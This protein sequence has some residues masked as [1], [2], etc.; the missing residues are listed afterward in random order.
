MN[1][2]LSAY[3]PH[4]LGNGRLRRT[5]GV[6]MAMLLGMLSLVGLSGASIQAAPIAPARVM[7]TYTVTNINDSGVNSLRQAIINANGSGGLDTIS[8]NIPGGGL[9]T[10][11][12]LSPLPPIVDPVIIDGYSQ[13]GS[14]CNTLPIGIN[15]VPQIELNGSS[16]AASGL[17]ILAGGS[18][19]NGLIINR[20]GLDGIDLQNL[21][22]NS[23]V[24]NFIGTNATG[25]APSPNLQR[26][27]LVETANNSIGTALPCDRNLI[28][29][30]AF[31]GVHING[32]NATANT[33][34]NNYIGTNAA[35]MGALPN[36]G[37][38]VLIT[39][40]SG[41]FVGNATQGTGNLISGNEGTGVLIQNSGQPANNNR[42]RGNFIGTKAPGSGALGNTRWGV[43]IVNTGLNQIGGTAA[44]AGNTI[45]Y[46]LF[47][48]VMLVG[49][50]SISNPIRTNSIHDNTDLGI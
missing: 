40:A 5:T 8:F 45:A 13:P 21:G 2:L 32:Q 24:G 15:A 4:R 26:G 46:N 16:V 37:S 49:A 6:L 31:N 36:N 29:S 10:I 48:G 41:N 30:N 39:S 17:V 14:S 9:H 20:F 38:G 1:T 7:L 28:S 12:L 18:T 43:Q 22:G 47:D 27:V 34:Y 35:G 11:T 23:I 42:V 25:T 3:R 44:G 50:P 19:V 33:V